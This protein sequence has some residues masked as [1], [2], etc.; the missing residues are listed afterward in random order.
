MRCFIAVPIIG[1]ART[2]AARFQER[3][4][5]KGDPV[6]WVVPR[7][8]HLTL[9]FLG[10]V[11]DSIIEAMPELFGRALRRHEPFEVE[12][13]GAG[14]FPNLNKPRVIWVGVGRGAEALASLHN[15]LKGPLAQLGLRT[16][17]RP[18]KPH[19]TL[20]RARGAIGRPCRE[21]IRR[22]RDLGHGSCLVSRVI[23]Y[24]SVLRPSG[25]VYRSVFEVQLSKT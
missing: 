18:F 17:D 7:N 19:L 24:Q 3:L 10:E 9:H 22:G 21:E 13:Q 6:K 5:Q 14:T 2:G 23:L 15:A 25:P 1:E 11:E 4:R 12:L 20:G 16:E 8:F